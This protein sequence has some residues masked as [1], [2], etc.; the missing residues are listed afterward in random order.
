MLGSLRPL[1]LSPVLCFLGAMTTATACLRE[2]ATVVAPVDVS[3]A[4]LPDAQPPQVNS[5]AAS[6]PKDQCTAKLTAEPIDTGSGCTLDERISKSA[7]MLQFPCSGSGKTAAIFGEHRFEGMMTDGTV[8]LDLTTELDWEDGCHWQT[9]QKLR[10]ELHVNKLTWSYT[11]APVRGSN[12]YGSCKASA[13]IEIEG[14][15][16]GAD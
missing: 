9:K 3:V 8:T 11:E 1:S 13:E 6:T 15:A 5:T 4:D 7:G 10:G 12:C 2:G 16:G 14:P